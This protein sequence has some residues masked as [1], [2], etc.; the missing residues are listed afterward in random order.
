MSFGS[1]KDL[2][3]DELGDLYDAET[4]TVRAF[5]RLSDAARAHQLRALLVKRAAESRLHLERLQLIFTHWGE[6][7]GLY[8][9]LGIEGIVQEADIRLNRAATDD[10]RDQVIMGAARR[11]ESYEAAAYGC[12]RACARLLNRSDEARLLQ[13][14]CEEK[15]RAARKIAELAEALADVVQVEALGS[16]RLE[17]RSIA[18]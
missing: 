3:L 2:Y 7:P 18:T 10:V 12:A 14:T 11:I 15:A 13:D 6:R 17:H 16:D 8:P 1:L 4:Q 5:T 9:C